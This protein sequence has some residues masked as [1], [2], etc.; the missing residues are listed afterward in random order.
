MKNAE[1]E[2]IFS[3]MD[4]INESEAY[5]LFSREFP[6]NIL[7]NLTKGGLPIPEIPNPTL[8]E[9][10]EEHLKKE[11]DLINFVHASIQIAG[12][13]PIS[14]EKLNE[15][16]AKWKKSLNSCSSFCFEIISSYQAIRAEVIKTGIAPAEDLTDPTA[17][18]WKK[19]KEEPAYKYF[20]N[21]M[22]DIHKKLTFRKMHTHTWFPELFSE[23]EKFLKKL[24]F[25][26]TKAELINFAAKL[27]LDIIEQVIHEAIESIPPASKP[28]EK[29]PGDHYSIENGRL[30]IQDSELELM[31]NEPFNAEKPFH[32]PSRFFSKEGNLLAEGWFYNGKR[33]GKNWQY[34]A[35][36]AFYSLQRFKEGE[37][38]GKQEYFYD[39][40]QKKS[41]INYSHGLLDGKV[42]LYHSNGVLAR[43]IYFS[44]GKLHGTEKDWRPNGQQISENQYDHNTPM[45]I[46]RKWHANGVLEVEKVYYDSVDHF[47]LRKWDEQG[48]LVYED[49]YFKDI[50]TELLQESKDRRQSLENLKKQL[51]QLKSKKKDA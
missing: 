27:Q 47:D 49:L 51:E 22:V 41:I 31:I 24:E 35:S 28:I 9:F 19:M 17:D 6:K 50:G 34:Y 10:A 20:L 37:W 32:G 25:G 23:K 14:K 11:F 43:E 4:W 21:E 12:K 7:F 42:E 26:E 18:V 48:F 39:N 46:S 40:G 13:M 33:V 29:M 8:Q 45:G 44:E 38:H 36:G 15:T 5:A 2:Q 16:Y 1:G 30:I 3:R